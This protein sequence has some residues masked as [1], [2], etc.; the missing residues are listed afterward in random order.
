V[1]PDPYPRIH[2]SDYWMRIQIL[3]FS[4]LTFKMPAKKGFFLH[5][6]CLLLFEELLPA[7]LKPL[8]WTASRG[9]PGSTEAAASFSP[10]TFLASGHQ[11]DPPPFH[12][13]VVCGTRP[14]L[15]FQVLVGGYV[16]TPNAEMWDSSAPSLFIIPLLFFTFLCVSGFPPPGGG[17]GGAFPTS[18]CDFLNFT[19]LQWY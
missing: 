13:S 8:T 15:S 12:P 4:S 14:F 2:A 17:G 9:Q 18:S 1:D 6:L 16:Q 5:F 10:P 19:R 3:L 11:P 7:P